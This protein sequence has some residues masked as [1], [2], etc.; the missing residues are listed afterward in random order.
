MT[1]HYR[2]PIAI[3]IGLVTASL[4]ATEVILTRIFSV[5]IWYHFAF[6]AI[7]VALFGTG[8]AAM[9]VHLRQKRIA[10]EATEHLL[11][12]SALALAASIA[13][14]DIGLINVP[15]DWFSFGQ[16][17]TLTVRLVFVFVLAALPFFF[18]GVVMSLAMTRFPDAIH[19]LYFWDLLGA[20]A[21]C[22]LTIPLLNGWGG[23]KAL[24]I[25]AGLAVGAA[26]ALLPLL[27]RARAKALGIGAVALMLAFCAI[28]ALNT[29]LG[30]LELR[31]AKGVNLREVRPEFNAWNS[32]S[33]VTVLPDSDFLGWGLS[34]RYAAP[35]AEQKNLVI[36]M[37]AMTPL[38]HFDGLFTQVQHVYHD[39]SALVYRVRPSPK[40]VCIIGAGGGRDVLAALVAGTKKVTAVEINPIIVEQVVKDKY[41]KFT[42]DIY[43]RRGVD[44]H[45]DDGRS[46]V[47]RSTDLYDV[48]LLSMVDTSAATAAGAYAMTENGLY[49]SDAFKDYLSK[50]AKNGVLSVSTVSLPGLPVGARLASV[51][52]T[53]LLALGRDPARSVAVVQTP[54]LRL[55]GATLHNYLIKPSGFSD[56]DLESLY[57]A[58]ERLGFIPAY[59][60][61]IPL[62]PSNTE[63]EWIAAILRSRDSAE[64]ERTTRTWPMDVS[65]VDDNR[66]FF[67]YMDRWQDLIQAFTGRSNPKRLFG[68]GLVILS[69]IA[70]I[71][72]AMVALF[73]LVP[74]VVARKELSAGGGAAGWDLA[75]VACLGIGFMFFEI[76]LIQRL[77][78]YIGNPTTTF[79][80]VIFILL[81]FGG[82][83]SRL[84]ARVTEPSA[85]RLLLLVILTLLVLY[86]IAL[87]WSISP[88]A[89]A[90]RSWPTAARAALSAALIAP[91]GLMLGMP[92]PAGLSAVARRAQ[93]RI[94][95]LWSVNSAASVLGSV[96][97]SAI[98]LQ[99]GIPVTL[100]LG[101]ALYLC[102]AA[103]W[104]K[105]S[106]PKNNPAA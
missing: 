66:P 73:L 67:F 94:A 104:W 37:N 97:A 46:F 34:P 85:A 64:L 105:V 72:A 103:L 41:R 88:L 26:L 99:A 65:S 2:L 80:V 57:G 36:D 83:G 98:S 12:S 70:A 32:F 1:P 50:L 76:A 27:S 49:T 4:M 100:R 78:I 52:R 61:G 43:R 58:V 101:A 19:R 39:L 24:L 17:T 54:W 63:Q 90:T 68:N 89:E 95:W 87:G 92:F 9:L 82:L 18:G 31:V 47:R 14:L 13:I 16:F 69:K 62:L 15:P 75:Y 23:P 30:W 8:V 59:L 55:T 53:A 51:A 74:L 81:L 102:A 3:A 20:A 28:G 40:R 44:V 106:N 5:I 93:T 45:V 33:M 38:T 56:Q 86:S 91:L 60:P 79:V 84:S 7:S 21:G 35:I 22:L 42:G 96:L 11:A 48:V 77:L 10:P 71:A 25:V 29:R 6:L